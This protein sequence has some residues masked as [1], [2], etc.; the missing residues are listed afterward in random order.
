M[1]QPTVLDGRALADLA[2]VV[3]TA[4][5]R[6]YPHMLIQELH[7]DR[8]VVPPRVLNPSFFG[9]YDWHSAVHSHWTLVRCLRAGVPAEIAAAIA[10][11]LDDHLS[12]ERLA[13]ELGFY[14]SPGG[15]TA[16][17][18]YGW[19]WLVM[20]HAECVRL[21]NPAGDR[22]AGALDQLSA[23][24]KDRLR[25]YLSSTLAFPIR[26]GTHANTAFC[27]QLLHQAA[28]AVG[29]RA[30][31]DTVVDGVRKHYVSDQVL[32]WF[33]PP[34]GSDFLDPALVEAALVAKVL[35]ADD[36]HAWFDRVGP[37]D[38]MPEWG[39]PAF[40]PGGSDPGTLHLEGLVMSRAWCL[41]ALGKL[42]GSGVPLGRAA[43]SG[44]DAHLAAVSAIDPTD[45]FSRAHW[46]PT[47]AVYLDGWIGGSL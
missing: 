9:S 6:E 36:F 21:A 22:W 38:G 14:S 7:S 1:S 25:E 40:A 44:R 5:G 12:P 33:D 18:P 19:A 34:S 47:F 41:D 23:L 29:D 31:A 37:A 16:E 4:V 46:L 30:L 42:L 2:A 10:D 17:R 27:L 26:S 3:I 35:D 11:T 8:D 45:G 28:V 20:L 24:F 43:L 32:G 15:R 39:P 13:G